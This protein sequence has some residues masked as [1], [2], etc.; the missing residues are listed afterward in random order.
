M[1]YDDF[2]RWIDVAEWTDNPFILALGIRDD[3][4]TEGRDGRIG[5][6]YFIHNPT[7][8]SEITLTETEDPD[9]DAQDIIFCRKPPPYTV[10]RVKGEPKYFLAHQMSFLQSATNIDLEPLSLSTPEIVETSTTNGEDGR[11]VRFGLFPK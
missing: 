8:K 7:F 4:G 3:G 1:P 11:C 10:A 5:Q 6:F 9:D 2:E